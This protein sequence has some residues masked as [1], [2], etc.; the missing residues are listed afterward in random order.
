MCCLHLIKN[1]PQVVYWHSWLNHP[2]IEDKIILCWHE[3]DAYSFGHSLGT[4]LKYCT[5]VHH[6]DVIYW[7]NISKSNLFSYMSNP[8]LIITLHD[9]NG[10]YKYRCGVCFALKCLLP[11]GG[12]IIPSTNMKTSIL[13]EKGCIH[14]KVFKGAR[15]P[16]QT[17]SL[18]WM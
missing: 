17:W 9:E 6:T 12:A 14:N 8:V 10:Q 3:H 1:Q 15:A 7:R 18:I 11:G 13:W 16:L 2:R 5:T 4:I